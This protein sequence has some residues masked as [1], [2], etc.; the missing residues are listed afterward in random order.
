MDMLL[1]LTS[2]AACLIAAVRIIVL[3]FRL[4]NREKEIAEA[5][6]TDR[7]VFHEE[8]DDL[9]IREEILKSLLAIFGIWVCPTSL[10][11]VWYCS[12]AGLFA[13]VVAIVSIIAGFVFTIR[14]IENRQA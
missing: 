7:F 3:I 12:Y 6:S 13:K 4:R 11:Y 2:A 5:E 10:F 9:C 1:M 8:I 14:A